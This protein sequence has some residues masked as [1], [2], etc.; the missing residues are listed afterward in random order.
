MRFNLGF[1]VSL[2]HQEMHG[3]WWERDCIEVDLGYF[4]GNRI[5]VCLGCSCIARNERERERAIAN[6]SARQQCL[7][8][9]CSKCNC[10][11][12]D[13]TLCL[14]T[15]A[16]PPPPPPHGEE[17]GRSGGACCYA[18]VCSPNSTLPISNFCSTPHFF[19][20]RTG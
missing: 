13:P 19:P 3:G 6:G 10:R 2:S 11:V 16:P 4:T 9:Q 1:R 15:K 17:G 5:W 18:S 12:Q 14:T 8:Q 7:H 20:E